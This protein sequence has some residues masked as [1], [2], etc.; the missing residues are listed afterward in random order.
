MWLA[1]ILFRS[2]SRLQIHASRLLLLGST[3]P[4]LDLS[5]D[6][7]HLFERYNFWGWCLF[8]RL[9]SDRDSILIEILYLLILSR[10]FE[11]IGLGAPNNSL[12]SIYSLWQDLHVISDFNN[13]NCNT[14]LAKRFSSF[15][16]YKINNT[17]AVCLWLFV[18]FLVNVQR[19]ANIS[20]SSCSFRY[21]ILC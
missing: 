4:L 2:V 12:L 8:M 18:Y 14:P 21:R 19:L 16:A 10:T 9:H 7:L 15:M 11:G 5:M 3:V 13:S 1:V 17:P 6:W 20:S